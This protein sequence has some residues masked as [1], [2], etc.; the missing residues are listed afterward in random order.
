M[1]HLSALAGLLLALSP[2]DKPPPVEL[3]TVQKGGLTPLFELEGS[4]E[5]IETAECKI[6]MEA[7]QG[8]LLIVTV[9]AQGET[10][11]KG[12]PILTLERAPIEKQVAVAENDLRGVRAALEK[13]QADLALGT[14]SDALALAQSR[15]GL[16]DAETN[17][18]L[19]DE[20]HG[21][22]MLQQADL[23][24][25]HSEEH[26]A[27]QK[28]ELDQLEKMYKSEELT[29]ATSEIVVRRARRA[30]DRAQVYLEMTRERAKVT[31]T[32]NHPQQRRTFAH[33]V[34]AALGS[35]DSLL[36]AQALANVQRETGAVRAKAAVTQQEE[37]TAKLKRDIGNFT[38]DAPF[39]GHLFH[40]QFQNGTWTTLKLRPGEKIQP[41]QTVLTLAGARTRVRANLPEADYFDV[42]SGQTA[43]VAPVAAPEAKT[44]GEVGAKSIVAATTGFDL[45]IDLRDS[46]TDLLPGMK[47]KVT[48]KGKAIREILIIPCGAVKVTGAKGTVT[49]S[50]DGKTSSRDV[51]VGKSDGKMTHIKSGLETGEKVVLPK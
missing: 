37:Q 22:R 51:T 31:K 35:L 47:A 5:S 36:V 32:V 17:L 2:Q 12:D 18:K 34:E 6:R 14:R 7:Y 13:A 30:L 27:D 48:I 1:L 24:V 39:D 29:N 15:D 50:K 33:A 43:T 41:G 4:Y 20:V 23:S 40:G 16:K 38:W 42:V 26:I 25:Q 46:P 45:R 11:R 19:F 21:K 28:E 3:H 44:E 49:V 10:I 8:E 9:A